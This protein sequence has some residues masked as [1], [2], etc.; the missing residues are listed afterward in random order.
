MPKFAQQKSKDFLLDFGRWRKNTGFA[1]EVLSKQM[2]HWLCKL[3]LWQSC[4]NDFDKKWTTFCSRFE[5]D[6]VF[7]RKQFCSKKYLWPLKR[8]VLKNPQKSFWQKDLDFS[9]VYWKWKKNIFQ[10]LFSF[11]KVFRTY[12]VQFWKPRSLTFAKRPYIFP[13]RSQKTTKNT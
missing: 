4:R 3:Q 11:L 12:F 1:K 7:Y 13:L 6:E 2:L 9:L 10:K 8:T 5:N